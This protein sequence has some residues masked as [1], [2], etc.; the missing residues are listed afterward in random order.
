[1]SLDH[2]QPARSIVRSGH[3]ASASRRPTNATQQDDDRSSTCALSERLR[4]GAGQP[5]EARAEAVF[6]GPIED[7]AALPGGLGHLIRG[8]TAGAALSKDF[9]KIRSDH[10][11][12]QSALV[13]V[14]VMR[15][16][17]IVLVAV[18][19]AVAFGGWF[20]YE[21]LFDTD[22][23]DELTTDAAL[24]QLQSDLEAQDT[25][26]DDS[27]GDE[28]VEE[29][30]QTTE[31]ANEGTDDS[32]GVPEDTADAQQE[33][34]ESAASGVAGV[35]TVDDEF[36]DF[37]FETASGSFA[38]F[39]VQKELF[40]GGE[41]TAVGRTGG[42]T[43]DLTIGAAELTSAE[44][45]VQMTEIVSDE[46]ARENAIRDTVKAS[47]FPTAQFVLMSPVALDTDA[48]ATGVTVSIAVTG[49]LTIAGVTNTETIAIDATTASEGVGLIVGS[50]DLVWAD[51]G[52]TAPDSLS[53]TVA[54]DGI[55]E[56][57]LIVRL[58]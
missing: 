41:V 58:G 14:K 42:V 31:S 47:E 2:S 37:D 46:S 49:D 30:V 34:T 27:T 8:A 26:A 11:P 16:R 32:A 13:T 12:G 33:A 39:R 24:S 45:V 36:G 17:N 25:V 44:I 40:V 55:L 3:C 10:Q 57:Q 51:Y 23:P 35:W 20:I 29:V 38:G 28:A 50:T 48:L 18:A 6:V 9:G 1:M 53:G 19:L 21:N 7:L 5:A 4:S 52:I 22:A 43:G 56:F 54:D 15:T